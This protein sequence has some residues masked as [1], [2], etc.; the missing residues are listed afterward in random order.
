MTDLSTYE[1]RRAAW[2]DELGSPDYVQY[3]GG[4]LRTTMP[5]DLDKKSCCC[6]GVACELILR[7]APG[8]LERDQRANVY[9]YRGQGKRDEFSIDYLPEEASEWLGIYDSIGDVVLDQEY[10]DAIEALE[11]LEIKDL[12]GLVVGSEISLA[13][14][15][16][17]GVPFSVI[18][19]LISRGALVQTRNGPV[20]DT[21]GD[22][23]E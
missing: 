6:L 15:N 3:T 23:P 2:A 13:S 12:T 22:Q 5:L 10:F 4:A 9:G 16:D 11:T 18:A 19:G 17:S 1:G 20:R 14:L 7:V 8:V 21:R